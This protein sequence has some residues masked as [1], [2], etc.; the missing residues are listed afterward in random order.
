MD[1]YEGGLSCC[2]HQNL[3]LDKVQT[4]PEEILSY[5]MKFR[6]YYQPY[7]PPSDNSPASHENLLRMY[8]Q[9]EGWAE[10]Y[11]VPQAPAGTLPEDAVHVL[12][13]RWKVGMGLLLQNQMK[14][15]IT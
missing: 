5:Q 10:E 7:S 8:Y 12:K 14:V 1:T 3:L 15:Y 11:D 2:H 4:P 9:T 6:F 13:G